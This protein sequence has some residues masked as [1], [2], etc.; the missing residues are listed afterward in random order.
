MRDSCDKSRKKTLPGWLTD[1]LV[2]TG[3]GLTLLIA[4]HIIGLLFG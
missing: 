3:S 1:Y 4:D 2:M